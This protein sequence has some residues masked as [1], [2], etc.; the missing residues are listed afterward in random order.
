MDG[1]LGGERHTNLDHGEH[2][3]HGVTRLFPP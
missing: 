3:G 2:G 1:G